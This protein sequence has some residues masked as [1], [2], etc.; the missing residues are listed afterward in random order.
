LGPP[1]NS[2]ATNPSVPAEPREQISV[3][4]KGPL[5]VLRKLLHRPQFVEN[6]SIM[7]KPS[8]S[9]RLASFFTEDLP[10]STL[11]P[12]VARE[13]PASN[14]VKDED[15]AATVSE[16]SAVRAIRIAA[17]E[18]IARSRDAQAEIENNLKAR[19]RDLERS[20]QE[21]LSTVASASA[22]LKE[23]QGKATKDLAVELAKTSQAVL[24]QFAGQ[25][26]QESETFA[27]RLNEKFSAEKERFALEMQ[28]QIEEFR[29]SIQVFVDDTQKQLVVLRQSTLDS[30]AKD[31]VEKARPELDALKQRFAD[32]VDKQLNS[33][34]R[35]SL[36]T[37]SEEW[38]NELSGQLRTELE[39]SRQASIEQAH[40]ELN[41]MTRASLQ[42]LELLAGTRIERTSTE[43]AA[44]HKQFI[45]DI[46]KQMPGI[47]QASFE[48]HLKAAVEEGRQKLTQMV[49][50]FLADGV[51]QIEAELKKL[52]ERHREGIQQTVPFGRQAQMP[53]VSPRAPIYV[54]PP[55]AQ[56]PDS[57]PAPSARPDPSGGHA[58]EFKLAESASRRR[59]ELG[60][61]RVGLWWGVK[62]GLLLALMTLLV[63]G[64]YYSTSP[65]IRLRTTP[66]PAFVED[67]SNRT[68]KERMAEN[69]RARAYWD[70]AVREI[71]TKYG[72]GSQLPTDPPDNFTVQ[73]KGAPGA[74]SKVDAG[75]RT[76]Y[77][78]KLREVWPQPDSWERTS[79][80]NFEWIVNAW[81]SA[82][83]KI[84]RVLGSSQTQPYRLW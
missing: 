13:L 50:A 70:I 75:A 34:T 31:A 68:P 48:A 7:A 64:V 56:T 11:L 81:N 16:F 9:E 59:F 65:V 58:P 55:R 35:S 80:W 18:A 20:Q 15:E 74:A 66:P 30:L 17:K 71:G 51:P 32:D 57:A 40:G 54:P 21:A 43:L 44:A 39:T 83:S 37:L 27:G 28:K 12:P 25:L 72:Y 63:L 22:S 8:I 69:Q 19:A 29:A 76:R 6:S 24:A 49:D 2:P 73:E 23:L 82:S 52:I 61:M 62:I 14:V 67:S 1:V 26:Q 4:Q 3:S 47:T 84:A 42:R 5:H 78:Q 53:G 77:W 33:E 41:K 10:S 46:H 36:K 38:K 60:D 79:N 45:E